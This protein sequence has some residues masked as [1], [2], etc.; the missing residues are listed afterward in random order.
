MKTPSNIR[1]IALKP[2]KVGSRSFD[3]PPAGSEG[4]L[5]NYMFSLP[6]PAAKALAR[7]GQLL[8][9]TAQDALTLKNETGFT[10][11]AYIKGPTPKLK[12]ELEAAVET[13][14]PPSSP[15]VLTDENGN[16]AVESVADETLV[17][18]ALRTK[19]KADLEAALLSVG[20]E[21]GDYSNNGKRIAALRELEG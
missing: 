2:L 4:R 14:E 18:I 16:Q 7:R 10:I 8:P 11:G 3:C 6:T 5:R 1:C 13:T 17:K 12:D 20:L 9:A 21:P 15:Q 19:R